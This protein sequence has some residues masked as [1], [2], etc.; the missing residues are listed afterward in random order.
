MHSLRPFAI[1]LALWG[2]TMGSHRSDAQTRDIQPDAW[3][4]T[5][6]LG[7]SV[8]THR[9]AA[10]GEVRRHLLLPVARAAWGGEVQ[11]PG[12]ILDFTLHGDAAPD[13]RFAYRVTEQ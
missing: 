8:S 11:L 4:A 12:D 13:G 7:R 5:G 9:P 1:L 6:A 2:I 10:A 3:V